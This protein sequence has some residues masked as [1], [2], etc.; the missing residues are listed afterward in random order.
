MS[1]E[2]IVQRMCNGNTPLTRSC[3]TK[4]GVGGQI[5]EKVQTSKRLLRIIF[6]KL[7]TFGIKATCSDVSKI[8]KT[9]F[10]SKYT[11]TLDKCGHFVIIEYGW[12]TFFVFSFVSYQQSP[13]LFRHVLPVRIRSSSA[14]F[15]FIFI[16][17]LIATTQGNG[18]QPQGGEIKTLHHHNTL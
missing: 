14:L 1:G 3:F 9:P 4:Y 6:T 10:S 16:Y 17:F 18:K 12:Q 8:Q 2:I 15:V 11:N 5:W 7:Q 13:V